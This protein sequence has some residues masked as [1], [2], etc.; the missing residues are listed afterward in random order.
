MKKSI[1]IF[2][3]IFDIFFWSKAFLVFFW[4]LEN[5]QNKK[6][7]KKRLKISGLKLVK[8]CRRFSGLA[9]QRSREIGLNQW[10]RSLSCGPMRN[11]NCENQAGMSTIFTLCSELAKEGHPTLSLCWR[12]HH[13]IH[14]NGWQRRDYNVS[15][16]LLTQPVHFS[17]VFVWFLASGDVW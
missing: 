10:E 8:V 11:S 5:Y 2:S 3:S 1:S 14:H 7:N 6:R 9:N 15:W 17:S 16:D 4:Y 13:S 12:T